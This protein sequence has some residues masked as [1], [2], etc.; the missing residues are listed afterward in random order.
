MM[1]FPPNFC[2]PK[3]FFSEATIFAQ[4][5]LPFEK[6]GEKEGFPNNSTDLERDGDCGSLV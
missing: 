2:I 1:F 6:W 5:N 3:G 4:A